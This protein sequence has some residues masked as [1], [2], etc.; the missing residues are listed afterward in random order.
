MDIPRELVLGFVKIHV[1]YHAQ[2]DPFCGIDMIKELNRHGYR[3]GPGILYPM[4]HRMQQDGY[5][6]SQ[7]RIENGKMRIY[8]K[9][10]VKGKQAFSNV[11]PKISELVSEVMEEY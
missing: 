1:L 11:K 5:L 8:Y 9:A 4:L 2:K 3:I 7:K 10:T 6:Q